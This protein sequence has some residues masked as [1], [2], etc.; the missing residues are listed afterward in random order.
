MKGEKTMKITAWNTPARSLDQNPKVCSET[1]RPVT[2]IM[3]FR[4][5]G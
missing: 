3:R 5:F 1:E 4:E 2:N